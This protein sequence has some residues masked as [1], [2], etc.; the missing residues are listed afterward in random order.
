MSSFYN[1]NSPLWFAH[2][3][4]STTAPENTISAF[5]QAIKRGV[6]AIEID[7]IRTL[8]SVL[9][10]SHNFDLERKTDYD[11]YIDEMPYDKIKD[12]NAALNWNSTKEGMPRLENVLKIVPKH[13]R[14]NIEIKS[15]SFNDV[16]AVRNVVELIQGEDARAFTVSRLL[17]PDRIRE[18]AHS[19]PLPASAVLAMSL[20][21]LVDGIQV[22]KTICRFFCCPSSTL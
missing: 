6:P 11:G 4:A 18:L 5:T 7:V 14:L 21:R 8:D 15:R 1:S 22:L 17:C 16:S 9:L 10:C 3:G 20:R 13:V 12:A 19:P 2:R